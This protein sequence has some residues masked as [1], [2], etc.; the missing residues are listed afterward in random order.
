M[1]TNS[2]RKRN[3]PAP[4]S[5]LPL[6]DAKPAPAA[7]GEPEAQ[8]THGLQAGSSGE[9]T[10]AQRAR[11]GLDSFGAAPSAPATP[12]ARP[13]E[14]GDTSTFEF[15]A[16]DPPAAAQQPAASPRLAPVNDTPAFAPAQPSAL[17]P[18]TPAAATREAERAR[19]A[20]AQA[21][22]RKRS[23]LTVSE[24]DGIPEVERDRSTLGYGVGW[25]ALAIIF[26]AVISISNISSNPDEGATLGTFVP[27][28]VSIVLAWIIVAIG[29]RWK[30][31]G[32]LMIIPAVV[33]VI[34]PFFYTSWRVTELENSTRDFLAPSASSVPIDI[35]A[36]SII[37]GTVET[38]NG[39]YALL[40]TRDTKDVRVDVVT[41]LPATAQQHA[42]MALAPRYARR[43]AAGGPRVAQRSFTFP[44]GE[45]PINTLEL[46]T[47][48]LD[49]AAAPAP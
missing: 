10:P 11:L 32:W 31:W 9:L 8:E 15:T 1:A 45:L 34:G 35:D 27:A 38:K 28:M 25:T 2:S 20:E 7:S 36:S 43:V 37:S 48:P 17:R 6:P 19:E 3:G 18:A 49:C 42:S 12:P 22:A 13:A 29:H 33:L 24:R 41:Y 44:G 21:A 39:C 46:G 16:M 14:S 4:L 26:T 5:A 30:S 23:Q 40:Q 47:A